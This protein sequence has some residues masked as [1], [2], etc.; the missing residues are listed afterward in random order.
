MCVHLPLANSSCNPHQALQ[1]PVSFGNLLSRVTINPSDIAIL[2][3]EIET[4]DFLLSKTQMVLYR[5]RIDKI[6]S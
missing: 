6:D 3:H 5:D 1:S 2:K 4:A